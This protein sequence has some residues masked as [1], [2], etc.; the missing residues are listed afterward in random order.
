MSTYT[1]G[2]GNGERLDLSYLDKDAELAQ[3]KILEER[4]KGYKAKTDLSDVERNPGAW[5]DYITYAMELPEMLE[6]M[7]ILEAANY[8]V[9]AC[10]VLEGMYKNSP[11]SFELH[12]IA[13]LIKVA[14]AEECLK[15]AVAD[16]NMKETCIELA[17]EK[18]TE[19]EALYNLALDSPALNRREL[20]GARAGIF[21]DAIDLKRRQLGFSDDPGIVSQDGSVNHV[22][23]MYKTL[24]DKQTF[25]NQEE[26]A[27]HIARYLD[28]LSFTVEGPEDLNTLRMSAQL[29]AGRF[30]ENQAAQET[31]EFYKA[32]QGK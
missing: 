27:T 18:F 26:T 9:A 12:H 6:D 23:G 3:A 4:L 17:Y 19:A 7:P 22:L 5:N 14:H 11:E 30:P 28:A 15:E 25:T 13:A 31:F 20:D 10:D 16:D 8:A 2:L 21:A 1:F 24:F 32:A 29:L